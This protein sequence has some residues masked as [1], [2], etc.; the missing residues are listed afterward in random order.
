MCT[1]S[2]YLIYNIVDCFQVPINKV[3]FDMTH[4][5][6]N[7]FF[8][9]KINISIYLGYIKYC[10]MNRMSYFRKFPRS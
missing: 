1:L 2:S 3:E 9:R 4:I 7:I 6:R 10:I 8:T 5:F